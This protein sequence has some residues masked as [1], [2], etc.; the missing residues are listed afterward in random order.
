VSEKEKH[1]AILGGE[2]SMQPSKGKGKKARKSL[3]GNSNREEG[4]RQKREPA[5]I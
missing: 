5:K 2:K 3:G 4:G 1:S